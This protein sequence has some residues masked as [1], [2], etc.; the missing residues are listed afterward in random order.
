MA[1]NSP[2]LRLRAAL[3]F[4]LAFTLIWLVPYAALR[5]L[6]FA[7]RGKWTAKCDECGEHGL[8]ELFEGIIYVH[9]CALVNGFEQGAKAHGAPLRDIN[10]AT[11]NVK[12][13]LQKPHRRKT[14]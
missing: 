8:R 1:D 9:I 11:R 13:V 6:Y 3:V 10:A 5:C 2:G 7:L 14:S 12:A 4:A